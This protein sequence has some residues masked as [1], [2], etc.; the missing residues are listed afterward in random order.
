AQ[1]RLK[2]AFESVGRGTDTSGVVLELRR[3]DNGKPIWIQWWSNPDIGG[4]FTRTMFIDITEQVLMEKERAILQ[5]QNKYLQ[6][7]IKLT[8]N[9]DE[10][11]YFTGYCKI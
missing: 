11:K 1:R 2:E 7:E 9:F 10:V 5:A 3:K 8:Y 4:Q 6:E